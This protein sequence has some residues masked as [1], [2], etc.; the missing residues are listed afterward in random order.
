MWKDLGRKSR[1]RAA[2]PCLL[3]AAV[4]LFLL[5]VF[6]RRIGLPAMRWKFFRRVRA[7]AVGASARLPAAQAGRV[8]RAAPAQKAAAAGDRAALQ[9]SAQ[10]PAEQPEGRAGTADAAIEDALSQAQQPAGRRTKRT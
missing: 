2:A 8:P 4:A 6:Q 9:T 5:E 1:E 3:L 7:A 10:A